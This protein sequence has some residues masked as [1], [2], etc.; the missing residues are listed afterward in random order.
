MYVEKQYYPKTKDLF[1]VINS[2]DINVISDEDFVM[3][4]NVVV[5]DKVKKN[6]KYFSIS[7]NYNCC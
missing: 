3:H 7:K 2:S 4:D 1:R 6:K 5:E